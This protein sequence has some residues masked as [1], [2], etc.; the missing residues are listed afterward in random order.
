[1]ED[2]LDA[3]CLIEK[4][5]TCL[6][7][8]PD[9]IL[10]RLLRGRIYLDPS[11][12]CKTFKQVYDDK[13]LDLLSLLLNTYTCTYN[14]TDSRPSIQMLKCALQKAKI[15]KNNEVYKKIAINVK[16]MTFD[17]S[18]LEDF[19]SYILFSH[20]ETVRISNRI[21]SEKKEKQ[22]DKDLRNEW[23]EQSFVLVESLTERFNTIIFAFDMNHGKLGLFMKSY[24][25]FNARNAMTS[26]G[27]LPLM[28]PKLYTF[29]KNII[30]AWGIDDLFQLGKNKYV[31]LVFASAIGSKKAIRIIH[32]AITNEIREDIIQ[33]NIQ[34]NIQEFIN[35]TTFL[36]CALETAITYDHIDVVT[37]LLDLGALRTGEITHGEFIENNE[38]TLKEHTFFTEEPL[39]RACGFNTYSGY[40]HANIAIV[41]LLLESR[42]DKQSTL[43][44]KKYFEEKFNGFVVPRNGGW[45]LKKYKFNTD[46]L[47]VLEKF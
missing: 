27:P 32:N 12:V 3:L 11:R 7:D 29:L 36:Q 1:M 28:Q 26:F 13:P 15:K 21:V 41:K 40:K 8:M 45:Y 39:L 37:Y 24:W 35:N 46:M 47:N 23:R 25:N 43:T 38:E 44:W 42:T 6:L 31:S 17:R 22:S 2:N 34:D 10:T 18:E 14:N 9:D 5:E 20:P 19:F 30:E 16:C 4:Q 33:D